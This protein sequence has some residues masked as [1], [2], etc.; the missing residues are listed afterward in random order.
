MG[1]CNIYHS[2][3]ALKFCTWTFISLLYCLLSSSLLQY[4]LQIFRLPSFPSSLLVTLTWPP[5]QKHS[6]SLTRVVQT[7]LNWVCLTPIHWLMALLFR[8]VGM[9]LL[10]CSYTMSFM[11]APAYSCVLVYT[12]LG[13]C[14]TRASK[15]HHVWGCHLHGKGGDTWAVL[16]CSTFHILQPDSEAWYPKV[17]EYC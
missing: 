6:R 3:S 17:H 7:W 14:D 15:G 1:L 12:V 5:Q 16:P 10:I 4:Y 11:Y 8:L 2:R 9:P 13:L